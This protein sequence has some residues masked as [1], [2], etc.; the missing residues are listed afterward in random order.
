[1][2][3]KFNLYSQSNLVLNKKITIEW[4]EDGINE[5]ATLYAGTNNVTDL[6]ATKYASINENFATW[7]ED[8]DKVYGAE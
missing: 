7:K 4:A 3:T 2:S 1:M 8:S 6:F 5:Y